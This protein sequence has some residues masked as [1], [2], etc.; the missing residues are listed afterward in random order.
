MKPIPEQVKQ[1]IHSFVQKDLDP[2]MNKVIL[3]TGFAT[4][5]GGVISLFLCGQFGLGISD[6]SVQI[7]HQI[8]HRFGEFYCAMICGAIFAFIPVLALRFL[9]TGVQYRV[10]LTKHLYILWIWLLLTSTILS[11]QGHLSNLIWALVAWNSTAMLATKIYS[12]LVIKAER[13]FNRFQVFS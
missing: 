5:I 7:N 9:S 1:T 11:Y 3:K 10:L 12:A 4:L 8:H 6:F 2:S 13:V